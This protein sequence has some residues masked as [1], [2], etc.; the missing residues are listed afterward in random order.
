MR[1]LGDLRHAYSSVLVF[2]T[3]IDG[4]KRTA[5]EFPIRGYPF[6]FPPGWPLLPRRSIQAV[7]EWPVGGEEIASLVPISEQLVLSAVQLASPG[8]WEFVGKLNPLEVLRQY[9]NDRHERRKDREYRESAEQRRLSLENLSLENKVISE[10][11][12]LAKDLGATDRDL[13]PL[14]TA[15]VYKPLSALDR[16]QDHNVIERAELVERGSDH[17]G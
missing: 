14:L 12:K 1:Y 3:V 2:E 8:F 13:A 6:G 4:M 7:R 16:H 10:R 5:R 9:L 11:V 15:L 17:K